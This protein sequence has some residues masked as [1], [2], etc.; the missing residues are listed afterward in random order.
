MSALLI[1]AGNTRLKWAPLIGN[2]L[3]RSTALVHHRSNLRQLARFVA[4]GAFERAWI[5]SVAGPQVD[6]ALRAALRAVRLPVKFVRVA[7]QAAG[8]TVGYRDP[9]RLGVDRFVALIAAHHRFPGN[10]VCVV[11]IGTAMTVDFL[12]SGGM[13][14]GG[15]IIPSP[16]LMVESLLRETSGIRRRAR[17]SRRDRAHLFARSTRDAI[18]QGARFAAAALIE[19]AAQEFGMKRARNPLVVLTGG[20]AAAVQALIE[21]RTVAAP[22]L[23]LEG[24]AVLARADGA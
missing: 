18:E 8:V 2:H 19:R 21:R 12:E 10:D 15:V 4:G 3:R 20:G 9:W 24:L 6:G 1:D 22:D 16:N 13:H 5:V 14:L 23:T 17:D 7:R 11:G